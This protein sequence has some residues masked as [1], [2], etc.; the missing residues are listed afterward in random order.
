M[1]KILQGIIVSTKMQKTIVVKV[2][3]RFR[4]A[5][6]KKTIV[7]H[8][9]YKVHNENLKLKEGDKVKIR[10]TRPISKDKHFIIVEEN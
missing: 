2:E 1:A 9:K 4:H 8:K 6:Y 7:K 3:R 5:L 10:E